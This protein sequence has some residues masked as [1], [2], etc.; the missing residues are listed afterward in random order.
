MKQ[1]FSGTELY[2][3]NLNLKNS[4]IEKV[5]EDLN[6]NFFVSKTV[7]PPGES[8]I[9]YI[10]SNSICKL[11]EIVLNEIK[12]YLNVKKGDLYYKWDWVFKSTNKNNIEEYHNHFQNDNDR[13]YIS[14]T[15]S[16]TFYLSMPDKDV[17]KLW[18]KKNGEE[19][20][21]IPKVGELFIFPSDLDH[22]PE[23]NKNST[24]DR[25]VYAGDFAVLDRNKKYK[26]INHTLI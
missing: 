22:K 17:G 20:Y 23:I 5:I 25:I 8:T 2:V 16:F 12:Q 26:K 11:E 9:I 14:P 4:F 13:V 10:K 1:L 18:F 6:Y 19:N 7:H 3:K 15:H 21:V 24:I